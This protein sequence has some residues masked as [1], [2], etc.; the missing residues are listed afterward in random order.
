[1]PAVLAVVMAVGQPGFNLWLALVAIVGVLS[2]HLGM[3]LADDY[4]DYRVDM[5][6]DRDKVTRR[7]FRAM[8]VKYPYLTDGSVTPRGLLQAIA[9]FLSVSGLCG[10]VIFIFR[11]LDSG[12]VSA[13]GSW[14]IAAIALVG[15]FL[16]IFYTAPPF[17]LAYRGIGELVI[18]FIFGP[19]LMLGVYYSSCGRIDAEVVWASVPVG[20]L[21]LN[22]LFTHSFIERESDAASN[23]MTLARLLGS[24]RANLVAAVV[25]NFLPYLLVAVAVAAG[26]MSPLYLLV[27]LVF[28]NSVWLCRSLRAYNE[29][30]TG[31]PERPLPWLGPMGDWD[32]IRQAGIDWFMMRWLA[33]RN[34]LSE[35]CLIVLVVRLILILQ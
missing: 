9:S 28:P 30:D 14:W 19:L 27:L 23:K 12:F 22:I 26:Y 3:N 5:L 6:S 7:G 25:I 11:G 20:L 10:A 34:I 18:G 8:M 32:G 29:G 1:M 21:V 31:V 24:D 4:F 33:A 2:A 16:G 17:K 35:F 15:A 13:Q